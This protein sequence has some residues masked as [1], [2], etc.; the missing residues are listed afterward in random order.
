MDKLASSEATER[1]NLE[2]ILSRADLLLS[3]E[4]VLASDCENILKEV[5]LACVRYEKAV[6]ELR[7][8]FLSVGYHSR[9]EEL[10]LI[11]ESL[12]EQRCPR[13]VAMLNPIPPK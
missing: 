12:V 10:Q 4:V 6:L 5:E 11:S 2:R 8:H 9:L 1:N 13:T 3:N 7:Q